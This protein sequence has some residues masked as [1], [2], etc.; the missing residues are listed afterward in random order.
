MGGRTQKPLDPRVE[1]QFSVDEYDIVILSALSDS[2]ALEGLAPPEQ[3][4]HSRR[5]SAD[6]PPALRAVPELENAYVAKVGSPRGACVSRWNRAHLARCASTATRQELTRC[7]SARALSTRAG[8]GTSSS[9]SSASTAL[10]DLPAPRKRL[11]P[12]RH[13]RPQGLT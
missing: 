8:R 6:G 3:V 7:P 10:R 13:S 4:R 1:R 5:A 12:D 11:H 9:T 2:G